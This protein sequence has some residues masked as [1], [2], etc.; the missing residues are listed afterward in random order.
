MIA[1]SRWI[2][3][4][5]LA[6]AAALHLTGIMR[7]DLTDD[8]EIAGGQAGA[9]QASLGDAFAD[10]SEGTLT[11]LETKDVMEPLEVEDTAADVPPEETVAETEATTETPRPEPETAIIQTP[12]DTTPDQPQPEAAVTA[13]TSEDAVEQSGPQ[14]TIVAVPD[15]EPVPTPTLQATA[16]T[17]TATDRVPFATATSQ[18]ETLSA[19]TS[20]APTPLDPAAQPETLTADEPDQLEVTQSLRPKVRSRAFE[21][22]NKLDDP[23]PTPRSVT[24]TEQATPAPRGN[25]AQT[26]ARAGQT[27]GAANAA[28]SQRATGSQQ[29]A[30]AGNAAVSNYPGQVV[31]RIQR[32]RRPRIRDVGAPA[33][34]TFRI[35]SN[36]GLSAV[37]IRRSSGSAELDR[38]AIQM[39]QRAAPFP[40]PPPGAQRS[41][42]MPIRGG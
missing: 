23:P 4:V 39:I 8:I 37:S 12:V 1:A 30:N 20:I 27:D 36:G 3:A 2:A 25:Q 41:F 9:T 17:V 7:L 6:I 35:A 42:N 34:V 24:R 21:E 18:T 11:A 22:R 38:A 15:A 14:T 29:S 28:A 5:A 31:R 13:A 33:V 19:V 40:P 10:L 16:P 32:V 26:N